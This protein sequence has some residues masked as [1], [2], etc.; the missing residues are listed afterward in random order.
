MHRMK[1]N[2]SA[3][4]VSLM[5]ARIPAI[6]A[7][8]LAVVIGCGPRS[9]PVAPP[10]PKVP[11]PAADAR[12]ALPAADAQIPVH[13][14]EITEQ[15]GIHWTH[16]TGER[17]KKYMPEVET[18]G[19]A[20]IDYNGDG[21]PDILLLNGADWPEVTKDRKKSRTALYRNDGNG[22]F[23]DVTKGSGLD[24]ELHTMGVAVGDYDNDGRDD[25]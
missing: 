17:G 4:K 22:H 23:T 2:S 20:F 13:F 1:P 24:L 15:A 12:H 11:T 21:K 7:I 10:V 14:T 16:F 18:P 19:C 9:A 8:I 6:F 3:C 5:K 25:L